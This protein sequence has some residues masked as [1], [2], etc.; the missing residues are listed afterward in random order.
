ML[1]PDEN[2]FFPYQSFE[3]CLLADGWQYDAVQQVWTVTFESLCTYSKK[4]LHHTSGRIG[5]VIGDIFAVWMVRE[6]NGKERYIALEIPLDGS[7]TLTE[8]YERLFLILE[9][10]TENLALLPDK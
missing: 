3:E 4:N 10:P 1:V 9:T 7:T 5:L 6:D 8:C 2:P